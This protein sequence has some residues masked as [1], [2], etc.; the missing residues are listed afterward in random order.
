MRLPT[1]N[2]YPYHLGDLIDI[3]FGFDGISITLLELFNYFYAGIP[4]IE[5]VRENRRK[6]GIYLPV[7]YHSSLRQGRV[8]LIIGRRYISI[9]NNVVPTREYLNAETQKKEI[10]KEN[11]GKAGVY[12]FTDLTNGKKYIGSAINLRKRLMEYF[13]PKYLERKNN[14]YICRNLLKYGMSNFSLA[15]V[16]YCDPEKCLER[17]DFYISSFNPEYNILKK[18]G[19]S[20]G[21]IH[22][23]ET[24]KKMSVSHKALDWTGESNPNY[25]KTVSEE[26]RA[27]LFAQKKNKCQIIEVMD[28]ETNKTTIYDSIRAAGRALNINQSRITTYFSKNQKGPFLKRY[29]FKKI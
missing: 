26:T 19:S 7:P 4:N 24:R 3:L 1:T 27:I 16:E 23:L 13:N 17:E 12:C 14:L 9:S 21:Y 2:C 29:I 11:K 5:A 22:R 10:L 28:L 25:G 18:A 6:S 8:N 20:T 15:I